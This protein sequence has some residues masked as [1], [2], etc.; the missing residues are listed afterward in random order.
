MPHMA[1]TLI[2]GLPSYVTTSPSPTSPINLA[3]THLRGVSKH[4]GEFVDLAL[5]QHYYAKVLGRHALHGYDQ[6]KVG[7]GAVLDLGWQMLERANDRSLD[8]Q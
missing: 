8:Y 4:Y 7:G 5:L 2:W 1:P 3:T 6:F